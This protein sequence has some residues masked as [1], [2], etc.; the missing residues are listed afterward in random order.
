MDVLTQLPDKVRGRPLRRF[1][2]LAAALGV[3]I[4]AT[5]G[6]LLTR[7]T[8]PAPSQPTTPTIETTAPRTH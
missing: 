2:P 1:A 5:I 7:V 3:I 8:G 4:A 6:L